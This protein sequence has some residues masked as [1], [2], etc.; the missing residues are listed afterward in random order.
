MTLSSVSAAAKAATNSKSPRSSSTRPRHCAIAADR[1]LL[2]SSNRPAAAARMP[3]VFSVTNRPMSQSVSDTASRY[4]GGAAAST[5]RPS[6]PALF[7]NPRRLETYVC[8][9]AR[10]SCR[11]CCPHT[12]SINASLPT[13]RLRLI[14]SMA[15]TA[16][17]LREPNDTGSPPTVIS[18]G[19]STPKP[20]NRH[21]PGVA[22]CPSSPTRRVRNRGRC[23]LDRYGLCP[24]PVWLS[25]VLLRRPVPPRRRRSSCRR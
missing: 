19:P 2:A 10:A 18:S 21:P 11:A 6:T 14:T 20:I 12:P 8:R 5:V 25:T 17:C 1:C 15:S 3:A 22:P 4:P 23:R 24:I 16:R 13:A 7:K 9:L